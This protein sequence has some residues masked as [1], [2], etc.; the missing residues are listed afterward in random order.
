MRR[1]LFVD[2]EPKILDGLRRLFRPQRFEWDMAFAEGGEA[3]LALLD[4]SPFDVIVS[5]MKMAAM[6]GAT[7]LERVRERHPRVVRIVLSGYTELEEA[8]RAAKVAHQ[9]LLK[10]CDADM[11]RIAI[12]R[13][14]SLQAILSS[15]TLAGMVG[16]LGKLPSAPQVYTD[17]TQALADPDSSLGRIAGIVERDVAISAKILQ[18]VNSAFFGLA[19]NVSSVENAVSYLGVNIIQSL[20]ISVEAFRV[21]TGG[22]QVEGFSIDEFEEH[23]QL[24]AGIAR[25][26]GLPRHW[27]DPAVV[28]SLLHDI[29]LLVLATRAPEQFQA[30]LRV[31]EEKQQPLHQAEAGLCG[32]SHAEIGAYLLGL[33]GLPQPVTEAV[34]HHHTPDRVPR[35]EFDVVAAVYVADALAHQVRPASLPYK[36][37]DAAFLAGLGVADRYPAWLAAAQQLVSSVSDVSHATR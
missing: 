30:A 35:E 16:A 22:D 2:D 4:Q 29:G 37:A 23:S 3:A 21:F 34:A 18:L 28:A 14:C 1:I 13:A 33:W 31:A 10:P 27:A 36:P 15:E 20:A 6:D 26:L 25:K 12:E 5:D 19:R 8:F 11:L 9:F 17:L 32:V 24:A 7:L